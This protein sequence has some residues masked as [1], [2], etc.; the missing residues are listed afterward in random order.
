MRDTWR[1][2]NN[3]L[4]LATCSIGVRPW[5][6]KIFMNFKFIFVSK[7]EKAKA[8][9]QHETEQNSFYYSFEPYPFGFPRPVVNL[10]R[11]GGGGGGGTRVGFGWECAAEA[12]KC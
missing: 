2:M 8:F 3:S 9:I 7:V 6:N 10:P 1:D 11:E 4:P 12:S 5:P